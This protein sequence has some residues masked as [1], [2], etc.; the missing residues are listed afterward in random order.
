M[1]AGITISNYCNVWD[2]ENDACFIEIE[3]GISRVIT[4]INVSTD[5]SDACFIAMVAG[6]TISNYCNAYGDENDACYIA[7]ES[8]V[9]RLIIA[10]YPVKKARVSLKWKRE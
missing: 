6:I 1:L 5:E 10:T 8:G 7:I 9:N 2:D 3:A 4:A